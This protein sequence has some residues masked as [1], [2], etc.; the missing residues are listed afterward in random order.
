MYIHSDEDDSDD[1]CVQSDGDH[2]VDTDHVH[3]H[4]F[5]YDETN[6]DTTFP[7][8]PRELQTTHSG[9]GVDN[10]TWVSTTGHNSESSVTPPK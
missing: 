5:E 8:I 3:I 10:P 2:V 6:N 7:P 9:V 4:G 1:H